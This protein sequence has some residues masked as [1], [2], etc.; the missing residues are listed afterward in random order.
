MENTNQ[1]NMKQSILEYVKVVVVTIILTYLVLYFIQISRVV[2]VSM[3]PT[4]DNG[5]IVLLNKKFY[6][7]SDCHYGDIVVA[8]VNFGTGKSEQIIKRVIGKAGDV[9][10]CK[11]GKMYRN[12]K[13]LHEKYIAEEME[14]DNWTT[15]VKKGSVFLMGDN[16]NNSADSRDLGSVNFKQH[17][18]GKV[19]FKVF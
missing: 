2:G 18:I 9:I 14:D 3:Q 19:F 15:T 16:R 4:Y 1:L 11:D 13:L 6:S 10:A 5:N 17:V 7:Y 8:D 12:G